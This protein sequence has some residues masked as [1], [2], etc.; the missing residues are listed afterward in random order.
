M[1]SIVR[2]PN[3]KSETIYKIV[4]EGNQVKLISP[5]PNEDI[6]T[7]ARSLGYSW[8]GVWQRYVDFLAGTVE[9]RAI[10]LGCHLL[11]NGFVVELPKKSIYYK[12]ISQRYEPECT[13][14]ILAGKGDFE[15]WFRLWWKRSKKDFWQTARRFLS[16]NR[17]DHQTKCVC[18]PSEH[19]AEVE[20]F[21]KVNEFKFSNKA[22][23][24]L[25]KAKEQRAQSITVN[26]KVLPSPKKVKSAKKS[27]NDLL[28]KFRDMPYWGNR[29][30]TVTSLYSHQQTA[31]DKLLP[32][33]IG[34]LFMEMGTGKTRA[35]IE[36]VYKRQ[37]RIGNV[38]W[39]CPVSLKETIAYE[40]TKHTG[41]D[42][43][44]VKFD[45]QTSIE[46]VNKA[47]FWHIVGI[48]SMSSSDRVVL[49]V[50][51][52]INQYSFVIID[53]SSFIKT[54]NAIRTRR[55]TDLAAKAKYRLLLTGTPI[56]QGIVD[57][58]SQ[59]RF[60][61]PDILSYHSFYS[62]ASNHLEY[63]EE[64]PGLIVRSH[65]T[66]LLAKKIE[67]YV[68]QVTKKECLDLPDKL[69]DSV[70]FRMTD[71]QRETYEQ[72]KWDLLLS[73]EVDEIDSYAI[74]QL[75]TALQQVVSGF[76][77]YNN[78]LYEFPHYR[79]DI[80]LSTI[81]R[82]PENEKVIVWCKYRYSLQAISEKLDKVSLF[83]GDLTE[84]Q[85]GI[86]LEKFRADNRFLVAT[87]ATGGHGLTL[88]ESHYV[89]FYENEF[90][91]A[92][93]LQAEDRCHRIGQTQ[94]VTYIDI[95]CLDSIDER[96][97]LAL[98]KKGNLVKDFKFQLDKVKNKTRMI[99]NL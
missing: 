19:F 1:T 61:S 56:S 31:V 6:I 25:S 15:N 66:D 35:A 63:S 49:T 32:I 17:Y 38:I 28:L 20:D 86:E 9:D 14:W 45:N 30:K 18:V 59:M 44:I 16:D 4:T 69:F 80:L 54:H 77:N 82:L 73:L 7:I 3:V 87:Q 34:A 70:Y 95:G 53:E 67:P 2:P 58:Y 99:K 41:K 97:H 85:R 50:N 51:S 23:K 37:Q 89:I 42:G 24:L 39:F 81:D 22:L 33:S 96:I 21:A 91:Y 43:E 71:E 60:L 72:A 65:K 88:N 13:Q 83:Y 90:K 79:M 12:V 78:T 40:I 26:L 36:L 55:I 84:K 10:E 48:E 93:R 57:L 64:Y 74:F 92:N 94:N 47:A 75:F 62:F 52:L 98:A 5:S 8:Q 46:N 68:Y 27:D 29:I 76:R 11:V